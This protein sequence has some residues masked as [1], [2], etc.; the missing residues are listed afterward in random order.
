MINMK[1]A[2]SYKDE[3]RK[4]AEHYKELYIKGEISQQEAEEMI[5]PYLNVLN[6]SIRRVGKAYRMYIKEQTFDDFMKYRY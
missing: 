6:F 2:G 5:Q 4:Q 3:L 1:Q